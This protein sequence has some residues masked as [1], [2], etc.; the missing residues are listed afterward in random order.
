M[1][2]HVCEW[3]GWDPQPKPRFSHFS[4]G[5]VTLRFKSG[6]AWRMPDMILHYVGDHG[7]QPPAGLVEDVMNGELVGGEREQYRGFPL[8]PRSEPVSVGYLHGSFITGP[9]PDGFVEKLESLMNQAA[10]M[11]DREQYLGYDPNVQR[12]EDAAPDNG[13][14]NMGPQ[15]LGRFRRDFG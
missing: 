1:G 3:C 7:Y 11:G 13:C 8:Q 14:E 15:G 4:S 5:D 10:G 2:F 9:V 12:G 6:R